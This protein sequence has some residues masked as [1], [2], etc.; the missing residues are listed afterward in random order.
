A[1]HSVRCNLVDVQEKVQQ[2]CTSLADGETL[3]LELVITE[4]DAYLNDV[5]QRVEPLL[6]N[7]PVELLR[8]R[9]MRSE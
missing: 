8:L 6:Q 7:L 1:L 2:A 5:Q 3:W 4:T 9:R